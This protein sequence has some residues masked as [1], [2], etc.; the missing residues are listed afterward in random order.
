MLRN[1][2]RALCDL[3]QTRHT[4][5]HVRTTT[6]TRVWIK[7]IRFLCVSL[8]LVW[9][10]PGNLYV[11]PESFEPQRVVRSRCRA[12][13]RRYESARDS[14]ARRLRAD[15]RLRFRLVRDAVCVAAYRGGH[16]VSDRPVDCGRE[17][18][19]FLRCDLSRLQE[20]LL[21][22]RSDVSDVS[23]NAAALRKGCEPVG[24]S[25][26]GK[27][28]VVQKDRQLRT[29]QYSPWKDGGVHQGTR[30]NPREHRLRKFLVQAYEV[31]IR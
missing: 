17:A 29:P 22:L 5:I 19:G 4:K 21:V 13:G 30:Q 24:S 1:S 12:Q 2:L 23:H 20:D 16:R 18:L 15:C 10:A 9:L 11:S 7:D 3:D 25:D 6:T 14:H 8:R 28:D 31:H 27:K 26:N